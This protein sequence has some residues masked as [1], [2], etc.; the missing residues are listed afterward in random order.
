MIRGFSRPTFE[1][2][3]SN[4]KKEPRPNVAKGHERVFLRTLLR[5][6]PT[7]CNRQRI[8]D[9]IAGFFVD[10][11]LAFKSALGAGRTSPSSFTRTHSLISQE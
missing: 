3:D 11:Y 2:V 5:N 8:A 4:F 1:F 6:F 10:R 7:I 9:S